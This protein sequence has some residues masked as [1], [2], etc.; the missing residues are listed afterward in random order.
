MQTNYDLSNSATS[1]LLETCG[2]SMGTDERFIDELL[3]MGANINARCQQGNTPLMLAASAG[4]AF[5]VA[6]LVDRGANLHETRAEC[7][8]TALQMA[9][10]QGHAHAARTLMRAHNGPRK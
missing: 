2:A 3:M 10:E 8:R 6:A 9:A 4:D 1:A 5:K 7:G